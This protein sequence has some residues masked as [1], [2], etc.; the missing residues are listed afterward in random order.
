[1]FKLQ[2]NNQ[3]TIICL[4]TVLS[5]TP[6]GCQ[7]DAWYIFNTNNQMHAPYLELTLRNLKPRLIMGSVPLTVINV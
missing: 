7:M 4:V 1:M 3:S 2:N 6:L 5:F